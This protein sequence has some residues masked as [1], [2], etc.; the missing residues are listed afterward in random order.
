MSI[1]TIAALDHMTD[2]IEELVEIIGEVNGHA[3]RQAD[4]L[5]VI[6]AVLA[7]RDNFGPDGARLVIAPAVIDPFFERIA[8]RATPRS[9]GK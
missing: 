9:A 3:R 4:A 6:A 1:E 2:A 5:E 8:Y 7:I